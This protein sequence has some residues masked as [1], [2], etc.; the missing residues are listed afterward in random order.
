[1]LNTHHDRANLRGIID[2]RLRER[3]SVVRHVAT[4]MSQRSITV[5]SG[6]FSSLPR[7]GTAMLT[8]RRSAVEV[9]APALALELAQCA[10]MPSHRA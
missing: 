8:A 6:S 4:R 5:M 7:R 10:S 1:M 2:A 3:T 9:L